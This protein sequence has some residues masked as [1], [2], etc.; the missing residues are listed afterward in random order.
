M[1]AS[2]ST[3][4]T[5]S[6]CPLSQ[7]ENTTRRTSDHLYYGWRGWYMDTGPLSRP[8]GQRIPHG[9][10]T[11]VSALRELKPPLYHQQNAIKLFLSCLRLPCSLDQT[12]AQEK[13]AHAR[14]A[15]RGPMVCQPTA[16]VLG[17]RTQSVHLA[18]RANGQQ[19]GK[20]GGLGP[21]LRPS[22]RSLDQAFSAPS[23]NEKSLRSSGETMPSWIRC[24]K[25]IN[26][27]Q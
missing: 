10:Q 9:N 18:S 2:S 27:F 11:P 3:A 17:T 12:V 6:P 8:F 15:N 23:T 24:L 16:S 4:R 21:V 1:P 25:L 7:L 19:E 13:S 5:T 20:P 26:L 14:A 22:C